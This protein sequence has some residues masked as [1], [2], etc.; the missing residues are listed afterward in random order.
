MQA[1]FRVRPFQYFS[2]HVP[3]I[4]F[5][6]WNHHGGLICW[7]TY[8]LQAIFALTRIIDLIG[9]KSV[10]V[11]LVNHGQTL[12]PRGLGMSSYFIHV[13]ELLSAGACGVSSFYV[14]WRKSGAQSNKK[15]SQFRPSELQTASF[16]DFPFSVFFLGAIFTVLSRV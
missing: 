15:L 5:A 4:Y 7:N 13:L 11:W 2:R 8:A 12:R 1:F 9:A 10:D 3:F 6:W 16:H 14:A